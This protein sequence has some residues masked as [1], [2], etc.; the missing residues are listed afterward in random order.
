M[1][2]K[3]KFVVKDR[4]RIKKWYDIVAPSVFGEVIVGSTPSDDPVKLVGRVVETTLYDLTGD[5]SQ[6]HVKLYFQITDVKDN[7]AYTRFKGH[8][9]ARDYMRSLIRRKSSKVQ[10]VFDVTTSDGYQL[11]LTVV[12]LTT[13][14]CKTS[15]KWAIRRIVRE[16][17]YNK[18]P[19]TSFNDLVNEMIFGKM[20]QEIFDR[21][22]KIYPLRKVEI[23]KSKLLKIPTPEG[24]KPTVA[25]S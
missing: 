1:S 12:V 25:A 3:R 21:A 17:L 19:A 8:D 7:K 24:V 2:S 11:R 4:W 10:G 5:I 15:Q 6:V 23:Y 9:L 22:K 20:A 16:Y 13:Y 14:R 18:V